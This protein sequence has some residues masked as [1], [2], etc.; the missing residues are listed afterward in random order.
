MFLL[1]P[2]YLLGLFTPV[3]MCNLS[4]NHGSSRCLKLQWLDFPSW[5]WCFF[6]CLSLCAGEG[7]KIPVLPTFLRRRHMYVRTDDLSGVETVKQGV[8]HRVSPRVLY[9]SKL[10]WEVEWVCAWPGRMFGLME[11]QLSSEESRVGACL[12]HWR[13]TEE[14]R[15]AVLTGLS[16]GW[17][18]Q[19]HLLPCH[20]L[21]LQSTHSH[22]L[23]PLSP[24][25][26][27]EERKSKSETWVRVKVSSVRK[28]RRGWVVILKRHHLWFSNF[29]GVS[30]CREHYSIYA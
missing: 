25:Y 15:P 8:V 26:R 30:C 19:W 5:R 13:G 17:K 27:G 28:V 29:L 10:W 24:A 18:V 16:C 12:C 6:T 11:Q 20:G 1:L 21:A 3:C 23:S 22:S 2:Y 14:H 7:M 9:L 4:F